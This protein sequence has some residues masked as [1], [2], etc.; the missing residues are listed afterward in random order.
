[1]GT[2]NSGYDRASQNWYQEPPQCAQVL[3]NEVPFAGG[4][5]DPCCGKGTIV[6][7]A[8]SRGIEATGAD[9]EDRVNGRFPRRDFF[10]DGGRYPNIV[11]NPPNDKRRGINMLAARLILHGLDRVPYGGLVA[12]LVTSNFLWSQGRYVLFARPEMELVLILS[13]RPSVPPGEFLELYGEG[14]RK[15]GSLDFAIHNNVATKSDLPQAGARGRGSEAP[16]RITKGRPTRIGYPSG[17]ALAAGPS[18]GSLRDRAWRSRKLAPDEVD[19]SI[20]DTQK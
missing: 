3:L 10:A 11:F 18:G 12:A 1:M 8:Q 5:H 4:V 16:R 15:G 9:I 14:E 19:R 6:A 13:E 2:R 7:V 20:M 17:E